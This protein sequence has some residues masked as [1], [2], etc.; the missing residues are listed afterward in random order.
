MGFTKTIPACPF[1]PIC[2]S[3]LTTEEEKFMALAYEQALIAWRKGEVPVGAAAISNEGKVL[4]LE[5]NMVEELND[6]TAHAEILVLRKVSKIFND[7]RLQNVTIYV[8]KEPCPM[9]TGALFKS[10]VEKVV[11]GAKDPKEGCMGGAISLHEN[12]SLNHQITIETA[13]SEECTELIKTFFKLKR[14]TT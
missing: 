9:C 14:K 5:H 11:Y 1:E 12:I 10:R 13:L 7:W 8:T 3:N 2:Q 4:A 6:A